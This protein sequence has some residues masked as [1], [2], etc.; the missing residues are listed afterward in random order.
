MPP[1]HSSS[2]WLSAEAKV[3]LSDGGEERLCETETKT[4]PSIILAMYSLVNHHSPTK[5]SVIITPVQDLSQLLQ[6]YNI[7][8]SFGKVPLKH[9][10]ISG[11]Y[12][13][14]LVISKA[15]LVSTFF[16]LVLLTTVVVFKCS[17]GGDW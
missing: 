3:V 11:R 12:I 17:G 2:A 5:F 15:Y 4:E 13:D 9:G 7:D 14:H 10:A 6:I 16:G 1:S 8:I